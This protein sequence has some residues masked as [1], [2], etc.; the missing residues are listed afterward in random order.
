MRTVQRGLQ[1]FLNLFIVKSS[2]GSSVPYLDGIRAVAVVMIVI[3]HSW[4]LSGAPNI[5]ITM[6]VAGNVLNLTPIFTSTFTGVDLFFVLSG[7]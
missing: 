3:R 5:L 2:S 6:P 4:V 1:S 7:F